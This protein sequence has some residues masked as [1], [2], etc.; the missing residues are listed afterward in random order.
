MSNTYYSPQ[1]NAEVWNKKPNGYLTVSEWNA[2]VTAEEAIAKEEA[3]R[4][5][6]TYD[7]MMRDKI[8]EVNTKF[9]RAMAILSGMYPKEEM[10]TFTTQE[11]AARSFLTG[12]SEYI[13]YLTTLADARETTVP[14]LVQKILSNADK[15]HKYSAIYVG[16]RHKYLNLLASFSTDTD[17][18]IIRDVEVI[19]ESI[20]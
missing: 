2:K 14:E 12:S 15:Y 13:L 5:Y 3:E 6:F 8:V 20:G 4:A 18:A 7:N 10:D 16:T 11:T 17:P 9:T 1:G 19:Y